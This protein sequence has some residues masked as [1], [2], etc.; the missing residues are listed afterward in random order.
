MRQPLDRLAALLG[1]MPGIGEKTAVRLALWVV[2]GKADYARALAD[3]IRQAHDGTRLCEQCCDLTGERLCSVC[4]DMR[5]DNDVLCVVAY[6]QDR[7]AFERAAVFGGRYHVLHGVLDPLS[8]VGP[9]DLKIRAL[10]ARLG[11]DSPVR[12]VI[13]ATSPSVEGDATA[14]YL[15]RLLE[16]LGVIVSRIASG[17][18]VG[19]DLEHADMTTLSR[20]LADRRAIV[21][22]DGDG[23]G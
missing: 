4:A 20:A 12:E 3:A 22:S 8:G 14:T 2:R 10:L 18:A 21:E 1:R 13:V 17:V 15:A 16:P 5:R 6:P 9:D 23:R 19:G 11:G 7:M